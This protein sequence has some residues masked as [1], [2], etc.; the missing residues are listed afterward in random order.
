MAVTAMPIRVTQVIAS[1]NRNQAITAVVGGT[2]YMRLVT[3]AAAP[4]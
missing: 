4:R 1:P 3:L 2:R